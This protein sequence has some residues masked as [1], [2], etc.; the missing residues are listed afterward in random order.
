MGWETR[1]VIPGMLTENG[2]YFSIYMHL[3]RRNSHTIE[4]LN[5][6]KFFEIQHMYAY[7]FERNKRKGPREQP[8]LDSIPKI[9]EIPELVTM[10]LW[11]SFA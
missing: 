10:L 8:S 11:R 1:D 9:R 7:S 6:N 3:F 4:V 5:T 2:N